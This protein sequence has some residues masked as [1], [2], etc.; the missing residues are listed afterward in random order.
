[1]KKKVLQSTCRVTG[2][3]FA[4]QCVYV[5]QDDPGILCITD[6]AQVHHSLFFE[7]NLKDGLELGIS[8][9]IL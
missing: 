3:L 4:R 7:H 8:N 5:T 9:S 2:P 6:V 1:M